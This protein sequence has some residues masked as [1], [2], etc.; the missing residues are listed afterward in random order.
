MNKEF[1]LR[2]KEQR[3]KHGLTQKDAAKALGIG[4]TTIANYENGTRVPDLMK[5]GE[6]ADLYKVSVDYL[7]G[8]DDQEVK[9]VDEKKKDEIPDY[10]YREYMQSLLDGNKK[11]V[12]NILLSFLKNHLQGIYRAL[13]KGSGRTLGKRR[14]SCMEGAFHLRA[15]S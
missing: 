10:S 1:S 3:K 12:R 4:Q 7:L 9:S 14:T 6:I 2:I 15:F 11:M 5:V 13:F 8:R